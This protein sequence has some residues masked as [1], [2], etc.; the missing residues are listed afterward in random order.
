MENGV[1]L[2]AL[3]AIVS[4]LNIWA[5]HVFWIILRAESQTGGAVCLC[6]K[7]AAFACPS[8]WKRMCLK[9]KRR[10]VG[11]AHTKKEKEKKCP[12]QHHAQVSHSAGL[13]NDILA[14]IHGLSEKVGR[15]VHILRLWVQ[16]FLNP[17]NRFQ[18]LRL[19][20]TDTDVQGKHGMSLV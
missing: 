14:A 9:K 18:H 7:C 2:I 11:R 20:T 6:W 3:M 5:L 16:V 1:S 13:Q 17:S 19:V 15:V 10:H 8:K 4:A 12:T